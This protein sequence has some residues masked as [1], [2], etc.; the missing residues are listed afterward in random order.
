MRSFQ[1]L[2]IGVLCAAAPFFV[3]NLG[4]AAIEPG[5][6]PTVVPPPECAKDPCPPDEPTDSAKN[7]CQP[8]VPPPD[9]AKAP[10][11]PDEPD[12]PDVGPGDV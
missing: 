3:A 1:S 6:C 9:C 2:V 11:P 12:S 4:S 8:A 10:C 5:P 7:P